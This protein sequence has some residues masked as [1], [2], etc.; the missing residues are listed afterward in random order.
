MSRSSIKWSLVRACVY[1]HS[2]QQPYPEFNLPIMSSQLQTAQD[3]TLFPLIPE[4]YASL[5]LSYFL[6]LLADCISF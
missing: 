2:S 1:T 3:S 4:T 6:E 5:D